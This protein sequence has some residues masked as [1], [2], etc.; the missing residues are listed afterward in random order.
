MVW[1]LSSFFIA[2]IFL[3]YLFIYLF[4][5]IFI[6]FSLFSPFSSELCGW[7]CLD[8]LAWCQA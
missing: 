8:V 6:F 2:I 4:I 7:Q 1:L 5:F 3:F